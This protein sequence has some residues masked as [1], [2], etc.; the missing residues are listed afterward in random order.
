MHNWIDTK[1]H[2]S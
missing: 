2:N 1:K